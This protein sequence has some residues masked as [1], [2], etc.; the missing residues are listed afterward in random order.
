MAAKS[1]AQLTSVNST[2]PTRV[3]TRAWMGRV[4]GMA[5]TL[6]KDAANDTGLALRFFRVHS[7]WV[8]IHV[9]IACDA[10]TSVTDVNVGVYLPNGGAVVSDNCLIDAQTLATALDGA[11]SLYPKSTTTKEAYGQAFW[12]LAGETEDPDVWYELAITVISVAANGGTI[13]MNVQVLT[14]D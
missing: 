2:P 11:T 13:A 9:G 1:S 5:A 12:E 14:G 3:G 7:S 4:H 10:I 6:E 8:P